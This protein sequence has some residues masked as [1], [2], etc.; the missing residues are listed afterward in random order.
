MAP[1]SSEIGAWEHVMVWLVVLA[2]AIWLFVEHGRV[3]ALER[4]LESFLRVPVTEPSPRPIEAL[5]PRPAPP[6]AAAAARVAEPKP[7]APPVSFTPP[8]PALAL[9]PA[10]P[11]PAVSRAVVEAWLSEKGLAWIGGSALVVG[12]AFLVGYAVQQGFF[13]PQMRIGAAVILGFAML[14]AGEAIRR[15][16]LAGFGG[17]K[18]A[19]AIVSGG[20][21]AVIYGAT[22]AAYGLYGFISGPECAGLL[23]AIVVGL[24]GLA[25]VHG[26]A[27]AILA[28]G[29]AFAAP[30]I[31]GRGDWSIET[32]T[33]YLGILIAAGAAIA[34]LRRW[35]VVAWT[36][37]AGAAVWSLLAGLEQDSLKCLLLGLE[38][39]AATTALAY[40]RPRQPAAGIGLGVAGVASFA[41]LSALTEAYG[42]RH[43]LTQGLLA[44]V[45]LTFCTAALVRRKQVPVEALAGPGVA[46]TMAAIVARLEGQQTLILTAIWCAQILALITASLW[47]TADDEHPSLA[48]GVGALSSLGLGLSASA[49]L[50]AGPLAP[51]AAGVAFVALCLGTWRLDRARPRNPQ[52]RDIWAGSAAAALLAT[53]AVGLSWQ[54]AGFAYAAAALGL[55][56]A[57][58][59]LGWRSVLL[60][61]AAA[62]ALAFA[63][64]LKPEMLT[65]ALGGG[66]GA[67]WIL[68]AGLVVAAVSFV[69]ARVVAREV[70]AAE[71]LRTV[72]PLAALVGAFVFLRWMAGA[73]LGLPL[74]PLTEAAVR[75]LLIAVAGLASLARIGHEATPFARWRGHLLMGA[76]A[77]HALLLQALLYN[78]RWSPID[79]TAGGVIFLNSLAAAYLAPAL[80]FGLAAARIYR[81]QREAGRAYSL[82]AFFSGLLWVFLEIRRLSQGLHLGGDMLTVGAGEA[83]ACSLVLLA[84]AAF[85]SRVRT[86][87]AADTAHPLWRDVVRCLPVARAVAIGFTLYVTG[88]WSNPCWGPASQPLGGIG[89]LLSVLAGY[90][91]VV[92]LTGRLALDAGRAGRRI[93]AELAGYAAMLMGLVFA[94]LA[95]RA[96]FHGADLTWANAAGQLE[97]WSYSAVWAVMGLAFICVSGAGRRLFLRAGLALLL[98]TTAKVFILDTAS[99]SGVVRA[100]SFLAL[101]VLLL[102]GALTARRIRGPTSAPAGPASSGGGR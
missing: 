52:A 100:G 46:F 94:S 90:A 63:T 43:P 42:G 69:A 82:I 85:A 49:G 7:F 99:L 88:F 67:A 11:R 26:E 21:A 13:T 91:L 79:D 61:S 5:V 22:W 4:E 6:A 30:L 93:E 17:H 33:V 57:G 8:A 23:A 76:A 34:W 25:F 29:G 64:L 80:V 35:T 53:I 70:L 1:A 2:L 9:P 74:S 28:L 72:S 71:T 24:M 40:A 77:L 55:A 65:F 81:T 60:S 45:A 44:A 16:R 47:A 66:V 95:V 75:T 58:R 36:N 89:P 14:G 38:P 98:V 15:R 101:G 32:L 39:L 18:L 54:W 83:L 84:V 86:L 50:V 59:R 19:A 92:P 12:G 62:G 56:F 96:L 51:I 31:A 41:T 10:P 97:T 20:G 73:P 78:P 102:A 27:L 48:A 87:A 3:S 37:L 68:V